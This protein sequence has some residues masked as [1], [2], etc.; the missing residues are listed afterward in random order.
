MLALVL[1]A[2]FILLVCVGLVSS[3]RRVVLSAQKRER[4]FQQSLAER[5][6]LH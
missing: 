6:R 4:Q 2:P 1:A 3:W 5:N